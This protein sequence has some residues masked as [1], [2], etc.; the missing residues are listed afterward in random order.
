MLVSMRT[1]PPRINGLTVP[2][3]LEGWR[4]VGVE[5]GMALMVHSSLSSLGRVDGG[6]ATVVESLRSAVGPGGTIVVPAFTEQVHDPDRDHIG[7][8]DA[9]VNERRAAV[10]YFR[11]DLPTTMGAIPEAL[12]SLPDSVRSAHPQV[13]VA[14]V[15]AHAAAVVQRQTLGFAVGRDSPFGR[16]HEL[17][18]HILL[19]GVGHNRNTFLHY[20]ES[21]TPHP[22]L[23]TRRFPL[24]VDGERVWAE[25]VDVAN[26]NGTHFPTV[27][28]EF[29]QQAGIRE[30]VVGEAPCRLLPVGPFIAFATRR[31]AELLAADAERRA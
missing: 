15:G 6:A 28:R 21:L 16:L 3:L 2:G 27:G 12:R 31:L 4:E 29:E 13:S 5:E 8:P 22:R 25:T 10:P 11:S 23:K 19:V 26:D 1:T 17:G 18:G 9:A 20:A 24:A 14:A 7:A 30:V